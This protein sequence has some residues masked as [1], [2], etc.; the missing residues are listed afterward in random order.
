M[1][2]LNRYHCTRTSAQ[3]ELGS[4]ESKIS[5]IFHIKRNGIRTAQFISDIFCYDCC[6]KAKLFQ[7]F[8]DSVFQDLT[9]INFSNSDIIMRISFNIDESLEV[10]LTK[11]F[12]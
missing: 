2:V 1:T 5:R 12:H 4:R 7:S 11:V 10:T 9:E 3:N 8:L 6:F